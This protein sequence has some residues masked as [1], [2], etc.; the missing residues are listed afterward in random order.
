M[1][2]LWPTV[3]KMLWKGVSEYCALHHPTTRG[4]I[5]CG[6]VPKSSPQWKHLITN[7]RITNIYQDSCQGWS[8][9]VHHAQ[10]D[11]LVTNLA[12]AYH[13]GQRGGCCFPVHEVTR[14]MLA[15]NKRSYVPMQ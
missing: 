10:Y 7:Y 14:L 11:A 6:A 2:A 8:G 5:A 13:N 9:T 3:Q 15:H 1:E 4:I 12:W